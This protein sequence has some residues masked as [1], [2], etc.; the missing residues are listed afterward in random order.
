VQKYAIRPLF[1]G[2]KEAVT[3]LTWPICDFG[4]FALISLEQL[5]LILQALCVNWLK[6]RGGRSFLKVMR[7]DLIH[8]E[9]GAR[10]YIT[11]V[12]GRAPVGSRGRARG[13]EVSKKS[14]L[15]SLVEIN[16]K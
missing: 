4:D 2:S 7:H 1:T 14:V 8:G 10:A 3:W 5:K 11:K 6:I 16:G 9:R 15:K 13:Q 12:C